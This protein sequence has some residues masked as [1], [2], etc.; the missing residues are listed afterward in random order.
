MRTINLCGRPNR[1]CPMAYEI[2]QDKYLIVDDD[3]NEVILTRGNIEV[4]YKNTG[5][6]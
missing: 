3:E 5:E 2:E 1:C 4:L 6:R